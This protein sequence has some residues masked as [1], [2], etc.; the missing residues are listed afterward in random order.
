MR[1]SNNYQTFY[2]DAIKNKKGY[3]TKDGMWAAIPS[4]G[5]KFAIVHN[6]IVEHFSKNFEYAMIYIQK[7][8]KKEKNA[9]SKLNRSK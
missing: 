9:R 8:I 2:K 3:V 7:G 1:N 4:N 6:G 5:K